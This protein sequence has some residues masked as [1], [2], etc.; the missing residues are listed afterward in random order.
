MTF[1]SIFSE[2]CF[3]IPRVSL[4][5]SCSLNVQFH[6]LTILLGGCILGAGCDTALKAHKADLIEGYAAAI[7]ENEESNHFHPVWAGAEPQSA[8]GAVSS[9]AQSGD[10]E[11][12]EDLKFQPNK[13]VWDF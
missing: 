11:E 8:E 10:W 4:K 5:A 6:P 13:Q 9:R 12:T 2:I 3:L 7:D 1:S